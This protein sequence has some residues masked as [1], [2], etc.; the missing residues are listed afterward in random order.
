VNGPEDVVVFP[1][2]IRRMQA[3]RNGGGRILGV[4]N[5]GG[6]ALGLADRERVKAAMD[7][8]NKQTGMLF[9]AIFYCPHHPDAED[10]EM[11]RCW[12][13]KPRAGLVI[14]GA[15][16]LSRTFGEAYPLYMALMVGDREEDKAC[17]EAANV[18]FQ[19]ADDWRAGA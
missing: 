7:E 16:N 3:W 5:Q 2:A 1:K 9:D 11:G 4:S 17:A 19:W 14:E 15:I 12:C 18:D 8:T 6:I 10:P 13:R